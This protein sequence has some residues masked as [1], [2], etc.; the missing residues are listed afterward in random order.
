MKGRHLWFAAFLFGLWAVAV[1]AFAAVPSATLLKAKQDA[2]GKGYV[3]L[4][5]H[6]EIVARAKK[7]GKLSVFSS[8]EPPTIKAI[9]SAFKQKYPFIDVQAQE[10][11]GMENYQRA[12]TE[13][14]AGF[15]KWDVNYLAADYY[16]EYL[17]YQKK[18]DILGM[19]EQGVLRME[20][21]LIDP[22]NRH[23]VAIQIRGSLPR[24]QKFRIPGKAF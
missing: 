14:K 17:P 6:D 19:A 4:T 24:R 7:E 23:V 5:S 3:F 2:E 18:F 20:P 22:V 12:L 1:S 8:Q 10:L 21:K 11:I 15:A 16:P 13:M 9:A